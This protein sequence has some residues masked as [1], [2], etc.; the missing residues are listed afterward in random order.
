MQ[1]LIQRAFKIQVDVD[2]LKFRLSLT[3]NAHEL[4]QVL[5][6]GKR[7]RL[8]GAAVQFQTD[9]QQITLAVQTDPGP[10][11]GIIFQCF[12]GN[13]QLDVLRRLLRKTLQQRLS[14]LQLD[15]A[16][17][18]GSGIKEAIIEEPGRPCP[19]AGECGR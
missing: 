11:V 18:T 8:I 12:R 4:T 3:L 17:L 9:F 19:S 1:D 16:G 13:I 15:R 2:A 5:I 7:R 10:V 6:I 14:I